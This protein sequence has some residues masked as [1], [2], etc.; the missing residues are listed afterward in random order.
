MN[1]QLASVL[2]NNSRVLAASFAL[3]I[4]YTCLIQIPAFSQ[5][6]GWT[7][8]QN[9]KLFGPTTTH[10]YKRGL[11]R[12]FPQMGGATVSLGPDWKLMFFSDETKMCCAM[13][14][15]DWR[16]FLSRATVGL[17]A[18]V[19]ESLVKQPLT[20][21]RPLT[22]EGLKAT[23]YTLRLDR[24]DRRYSK[25]F[26]TV[27]IVNVVLADD[28]DMPISVA[29][30]YSDCYCLPFSTKLPLQ[31]E[32]IYSPTRRTKILSTLKINALPSAAKT[33]RFPIGYKLAKSALEVTTG[34]LI[35]DLLKDVVPAMDSS[36]KRN[37]PASTAQQKK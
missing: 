10:I 34:G 9:D 29:K 14:M 26:N 11:L 7:I 19:P 2:E 3:L 24:A 1:R 17:R 35:D 5:E 33:I 8:V 6:S 30:V 20:G 22:V 25:A 15:D 32:H 21:G 4:V 36:A 31:I 28:V 23:S 18:T 12:K 13:T 37:A 27:Q 16:K